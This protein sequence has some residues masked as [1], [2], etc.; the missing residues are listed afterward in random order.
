MAAM[1]IHN[2]T[3]IWQDAVLHEQLVG[4]KRRRAPG[5]AKYMLFGI[6]GTIVAIANPMLLA[7]SGIGMSEQELD[8]ALNASMASLLAI[9]CSFVPGPSAEARV[10]PC[11]L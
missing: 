5:S 10:S 3:S 6:F 4:R 2:P 9:I 8:I 1:N 7:L 11:R